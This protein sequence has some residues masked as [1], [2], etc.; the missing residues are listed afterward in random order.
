MKKL[1][2]AT[3]MLLIFTGLSFAQEAKE[4]AK[5]RK[6]IAKMSKAELAEKVTKTTQKESKRLTKEGWTVTPGALPLEKQLERSF[7]MQYEFNEKLEPKYIMAEAM[8]IGE[9]YDA[10]KTQALELAKQNLAGEIQSEITA[11]IEN[12]VANQQLNAEEAAS[13]VQTISASKNAIVQSL[14]RVLPVV[15]AYRDKPNKN[16]E[17]LVRL[18]YNQDNAKQAVKQVVRDEL[19]RK[20]DMLHGQLDRIFGF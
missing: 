6:E 17:V 1:F 15:E 7:T 9:N 4:I 12:T 20:G 14:G 2:V 10:A 3:I 8:S 16:K 5:E 11:L 13:V 18:A 19:E